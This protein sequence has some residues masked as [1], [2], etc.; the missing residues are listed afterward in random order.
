MVGRL[1]ALLL[2]FCL[3]FVVVDNLTQGFQKDN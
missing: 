2:L 1:K 3:V